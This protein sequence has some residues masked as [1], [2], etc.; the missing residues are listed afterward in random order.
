ML[1]NRFLKSLPIF[2]HFLKNFFKI[3]LSKSKFTS[4]LRIKIKECLR[5]Y[6]YPPEYQQEAIDDVI[7]QA[8]YI[9]NE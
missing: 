7:K 4:S 5:K 2:F 8:Q 9:M 3:F 1:T 6:N